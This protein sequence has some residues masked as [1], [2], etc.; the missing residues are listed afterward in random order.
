MSYTHIIYQHSGQLVGIV[1]PVDGVELDSLMDN[2]DLIPEGAPREKIDATTAFPGKMYY[3]DSWEWGGPGNAIT[4]NLDKYK[5]IAVQKIKDATKIIMAQQTAEEALGETVA[6][7]STQLGT[8]Y[9]SC[10]ADIASYTTVEEV[11]H[12]VNTYWETYIVPLR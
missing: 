4:I 3:R 11:D 1:T 5:A 12:C 10:A 6:Y 2:T 8:V 7:T 9:Q